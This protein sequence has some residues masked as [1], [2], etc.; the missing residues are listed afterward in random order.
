MIECFRRLIVAKFEAN[1]PVNSNA[2]TTFLTLHT[3]EF[4]EKN[5][6]LHFIQKFF[7]N[8]YK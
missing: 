8:N 7:K 3:L 5:H 1:S 4:R 6:F 2:L